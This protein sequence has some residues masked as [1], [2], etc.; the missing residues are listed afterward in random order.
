M[1]P[2]EP[3]HQT[4]DS[5]VVCSEEACLKPLT[6]RYHSSDSSDSRSG[7]TVPEMVSSPR[8]IQKRPIF[9]IAIVVLVIKLLVTAMILFFGREKLKHGVQYFWKNKNCS[10]LPESESESGSQDLVISFI[11][12]AILFKL[13]VLVGVVTVWL[14]RR[15]LSDP[16]RMRILHADPKLH[17]IL[18]DGHGPQSSNESVSSHFKHNPS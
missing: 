11:C 14:C 3:A 2:E 5:A 13:F 4:F 17:K 18:E 15:K 9:V 16:D 10:S 1:V 8:S 7:P 6:I 12:I